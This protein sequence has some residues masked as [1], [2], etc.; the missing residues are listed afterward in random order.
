MKAVSTVLLTTVLT[1]VCCSTVNK[2]AGLDI[3]APDTAWRA[4]FKN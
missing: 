2:C 1:L 3:L 4:V